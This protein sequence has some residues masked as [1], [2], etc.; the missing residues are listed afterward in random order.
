MISVFDAYSGS[1][2]LSIGLSQAGLVVTDALEKWDSACRTYQTSHPDVTLHQMGVLEYLS[3][4]EAGDL[5]PTSGIDVLVGGPPCQGFCGFNRHRNFADPRNSEIENFANLVN[6]LKPRAVVMENVT[7]ILSLEDGKAITS[8]S[9]FLTS[10]GYHFNLG[11]LQAGSY[12]LPQNRWRVFIVA[13]KKDLKFKFPEPA[14]NFTKVGVYNAG[15]FKSSII[16]PQFPEDS[17]FGRLAPMVNVGDAISDLPAISNG[18]IYSGHYTQKANSSFQK[19]LRKGNSRVK[20]HQAQ[21]LQDLNLRRIKAVPKK[22]K[23]GWQDL[24]PELQPRNLAKRPGSYDNRFGRLWWEGT[25]NTIVGKV[26]PYWSRVIHP[27]QDRVITARECA[28]AQG[29]PDS[30]EFYGT[31]SEQ[32]QQIGNAVPP[33]LGKFLGFELLRMFGDKNIDP[34]IEAHLEKYNVK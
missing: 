33:P 7:G 20:N 31:Y 32:L 14:F 2:G 21:K 5:V 34:K 13:H 9:S 6:L 19:D 22:P 26:E 8:I 11:I 3:K 18:E 17:L 24:P 30:V 12:G 28:R 15:K 27:E 23:S 10:A 29:F 16:K 1:G 25:F 4:A